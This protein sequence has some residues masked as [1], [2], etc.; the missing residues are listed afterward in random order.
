MLNAYVSC[1][2]VAFVERLPSH[3]RCGCCWCRITL[4]KLFTYVR[5]CACRRVNVTLAEN[6]RTSDRMWLTSVHHTSDSIEITRC[7]YNRTSVSETQTKAKETRHSVSS[8]V[9][10]LFFSLCVT[11]VCFFHSFGAYRLAVSALCWFM[12]TWLVYCYCL[13]DHCVMKWKLVFCFLFKLT[14]KTNE[15]LRFSI[16][17]F[18]D[19]HCLHCLGFL[20]YFQIWSYF[21][22]ILSHFHRFSFGLCRFLSNFPIWWCLC[23]NRESVLS[24][25]VRFDSPREFRQCHSCKIFMC[26]IYCFDLESTKKTLIGQWIELTLRITTWNHHGISSVCIRGVFVGNICQ[27]YMLFYRHSTAMDSLKWTFKFYVCITQLIKYN[28]NRRQTDT[29]KSDVLRA[30]LL[31]IVRICP[32]YFFF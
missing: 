22:P 5:V 11:V 1:W 27:C 9:R 24:D 2:F 17:I 19:F 10:F 8:I 21:R 18:S 30:I 14:T 16:V 15:M 28:K 12:L 20:Y 13:F 25:L 31:W 7:Q 23:N 26:K 32:V 29:I 6:E 3:I 4:F